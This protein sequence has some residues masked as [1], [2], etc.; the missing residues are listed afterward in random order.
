MKGLHAP[1]KKFGSE[2]SPVV[3][4]SWLELKLKEMPARRDMKH[5]Q[6]HRT[7]KAS[8]SHLH[9]HQH[10]APSHLGAPGAVPSP[11]KP[12]IATNCEHVFSLSY[13]VFI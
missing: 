10:T 5:R 3:V 2:Q 6:Q 1:E 11:T 12:T 8:Q 4:G 9:P 7:S 13:M